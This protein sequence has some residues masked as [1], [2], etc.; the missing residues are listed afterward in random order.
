MSPAQTSA[1]AVV[2]TPGTRTYDRVAAACSLAALV[3]AV[4]LS[5]FHRVGTYQVET[6]FYWAYGPQAENLLAGRPY[7]YTFHPPGYSLL[8]AG[9]SLLTG[10]L[11]A[12]AKILSAFATGAFVWFT[13]LLVKALFDARLALA[14]A[15]LTFAAV[16]PFSFQAATDVVGA[17][18]MLLPLWALLRRPVPTSWSCVAA[19]MLAGAAYLVRTNSIAVI[20][21]VVISLLLGISASRRFPTPPRGLQHLS[22]RRPSHHGA[23]AGGQLGEARAALREHELPPG[24]GPLLSAG[25]GGQQH[26]LPAAG[27][28]TVPIALGG[29]DLPAVAPPP[30]VRD[31]TRC[32]RIRGP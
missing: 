20:A 25:R 18:F 31:R 17:L 1:S 30:E 7:G 9:V 26:H 27:G 16:V 3:V 5:V 19:G 21:G 29:P 12:A 24:G 28:T 10:D 14:T 2:A 23:L 6:D 4:L 32:T 15:L 22:L 8:V 13:Y 11:F